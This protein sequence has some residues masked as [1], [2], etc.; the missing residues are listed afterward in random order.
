MLLSVIDSHEILTIDWFDAKGS[1]R[2]RLSRVGKLF[3]V[4]SFGEKNRMPKF[5]E[6][7]DI[8]PEKVDS[9]LLDDTKRD[10]IKLP[11]QGKWT[12]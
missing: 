9:I 3:G 7:F 8:L 10:Y 11:V 5:S 2:V 4:D 12:T 1:H 6:L